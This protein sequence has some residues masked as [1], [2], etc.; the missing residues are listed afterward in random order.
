MTVGDW[1]AEDGCVNSAPD[2][3]RVV[4]A[5]ALSFDETAAAG[6]HA[7]EEVLRGRVQLVGRALDLPLTAELQLDTSPDVADF[8]NAAV[9]GRNG[10]SSK[11]R[12]AKLVALPL[13][14]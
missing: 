5:P 3:A 4:L 12:D 2:D 10:I 14:T 6:R 9:R 11:S 1:V 7:F 13:L 8:L